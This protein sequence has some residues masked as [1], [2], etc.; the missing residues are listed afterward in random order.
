[1]NP[2]AAEVCRMRESFGARLRRQREQQNIPLATIAGQTKIKASLLEALERDDV[3]RWPSGIF[4][5]AYLR[6]YAHAIGLSPDEVLREFL[7]EYPDPI[8]ESEPVEA[9]AAAH[10][11]AGG[12][13][14]PTRLHFL[15]DSALASL[16]RL[17]GSSAESP[18]RIRSTSPAADTAQSAHDMSTVED[19]CVSAEP[20]RAIDEVGMTARDPGVD[21]E[22]NG[23]GEQQEA[24]VPR[25]PPREPRLL[26]FAGICTEL[27][28]IGSAD[29]MQSWLQKAA[30]V[31]DA[32]GLIVWV[33]HEAAAT[34]IPALVH[35]YSEQV[36]AQLPAVAMDADN[37]TA[38]A[39]RSGVS[40]VEPGTAHVNGALAVPLPTPT[41]TSGVLAVELLGG[42]ERSDSVRVMA[43]VLAAMLAQLIGER[44]GAHAEDLEPEPTAVSVADRDPENARAD[45]HARQIRS[46]TVHAVDATAAD[47]PRVS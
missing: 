47:R 23:A 20:D 35:G 1:V 5:R 38:A 43:S 37:V 19:V 32:P 34:L 25:F 45:G 4:R 26:E 31:L 7:A 39:F 13:G 3:S 40:C 12:T 8:Q 22:V 9:I 30:G 16:S 33:W 28:R 21:D 14:V 6:A 29:Q 2:D 24:A 36:I 41:G 46:S 44:P 42:A 11:I 15:V 27:A 10:G 18:A 17:R